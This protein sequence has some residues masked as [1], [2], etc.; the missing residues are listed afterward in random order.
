M[1]IV[2]GLALLSAGLVATC[3]PDW[4]LPPGQASHYGYGQVLAILGV[5]LLSLLAL[6]VGFAVAQLT[7]VFTR[8]RTLP[9]LDADGPLRSEQAEPA[10]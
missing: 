9:R 3:G 1:G 7:A 8:N 6:P 4:A 5:I 10:P 2:W